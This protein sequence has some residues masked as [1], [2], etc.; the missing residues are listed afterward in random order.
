MTPRRERRVQGWAGRARPSAVPWSKRI[1]GP[2]AVRSVRLAREASLSQHEQQHPSLDPSL[3][4]LH[5]SRRQRRDQSRRK[6]SEQSQP[7]RRAVAARRSDGDAQS[8]EARRGEAN[9]R[10][11]RRVNHMKTSSTRTRHG[12]EQRAWKVRRGGWMDEA[13][14]RGD[15]GRAELSHSLRRPS[16]VC[17][18]TEDR[19]GASWSRP[20]AARPLKVCRAVS[21]CRRIREV[22]ETTPSA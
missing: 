18:K 14:A 12:G 8:R 6:Q 21:T 20:A 11:R 5:S 2:F 16:W 19:K 10:G 4:P 7:N 3:S 9:I 17:R 15:S 13:G 1:A 22:A